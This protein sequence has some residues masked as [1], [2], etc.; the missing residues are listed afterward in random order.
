M[1]NRDQISSELAEFFRDALQE[2]HM[3]VTD[4]IAQGNYDVDEFLAALDREFPQ[5]KA[6]LPKV[7]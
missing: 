6:A 2:D 3:G 7:G 1:I 5:I 4:W